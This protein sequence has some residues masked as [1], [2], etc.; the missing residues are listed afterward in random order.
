MSLI[1]PGFFLDV[2]PK[3]GMGEDVMRLLTSLDIPNRET[4]A[5]L[6]LHLRKV[7][8]SPCTKMTAG[9]L[10]TVLAMCVFGTPKDQG[11]RLEEVL[12]DIRNKRFIMEEMIRMDPVEWKMILAKK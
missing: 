6:I 4:L 2:V 9:T 3:S 1:L 8:S 7:V 10:A 5:F 12:L 11:G